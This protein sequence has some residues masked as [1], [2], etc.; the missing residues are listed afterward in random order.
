MA[1]LSALIVDDSALVRDQ[2]R[3]AILNIV[4]DCHIFESEGALQAAHFLRR[5]VPDVI[6]LD[7]NM[8]KIGGMAVLERLDEIVCARKRPIVV[9]ISSDISDATLAALEAR[10]AYDVLPKP[11]EPMHL[12]TVLLRVL[13]MAQAR[14]VLIVDDSATVRSIVKKIIQKSRFNLW[15]EE[16]D[17][18]QEALYSANVNHYDLIFLDVHMPGI[19]G[20]EAAGELLYAHEGV[21]VVL[22]SAD[23][24]ESVR[25]AA[26]HIG[27]EY[28]LKKPFRP[29]EV[30]AILHALFGMSAS[31]FQ[32]VAEKEDFDA[33]GVPADAMME[34]ETV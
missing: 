8:P 5:S 27:V 25:R 16:A 7:L 18:G 9:S 26:A 4:K 33:A 2:L 19:D 21:E 23:G 3:A 31:R 1:T 12:A 13:Q 11:F 30:D 15:T 34:A 29:P 28:F 20:L 32:A 17:T 6:F 24:D 14:R 10:G 22:M